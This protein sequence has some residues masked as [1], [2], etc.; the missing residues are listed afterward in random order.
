LGRY[1][2]AVKTLNNRVTKIESTL[3]NQEPGESYGL[4]VSRLGTAR[5]RARASAEAAAETRREN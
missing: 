5:A 4:T 2:E 1:F 3:T